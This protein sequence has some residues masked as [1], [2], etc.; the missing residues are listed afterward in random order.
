[1]KESILQSWVETRVNANT[2]G[3]S[4][5]DAEEVLASA[6]AVNSASF[7]PAFP[8]DYL[9]RRRCLESA[10][11]VLPLLANLDL[12]LANRN[13]SADA[14]QR[15][16]PDLIAFNPESQISII[17]ELKTD[18]KT[19]REAV[20]EL[21]AYSHEVRNHLPY[22]SNLDQ[23][24][25]LVAT[26]FG[27]LLDHAVAS[28]VL[29]E[30]RHV[31]CLRAEEIDG[32]TFR[33]RPHFPR[34]WTAIGQLGLPANALQTVS[35]CLY[36][37]DGSSLPDDDLSDWLLAAV[38]TTVRSAERSRSHGFAML[39]FAGPPGDVWIITVGV[40]NPYAFLNHA[41]SQG[42]LRAETD[43]LTRWY[44]DHLDDVHDDPPSLLQLCV[45][46]QELL[47]SH[48]NVTIESFLDW[49][50][51]WQQIR[52]R[53]LV[54][55]VD[56]WGILGDFAREM[57]SHPAL[58]KLRSGEQGL[59]PGW[60][61]PQSAIP[62]LNEIT[63]R[64]PF[65]RGQFGLGGMFRFGELLGAL[66]TVCN[67]IQSVRTTTPDA[68][69]L[70]AE[71]PSDLKNLPALLQWLKLEAMP[72]FRSVTERY[73]TCDLPTPPALVLGTAD[74]VEQMQSSLK[75]YVEWFSEQFLAE[76]LVHRQ[77]FDAGLA[78]HAIMDDYLSC[79]LDDHARSTALSSLRE[80]SRSIL[81]HIAQ[82]LPSADTETQERISLEISDAFGIRIGDIGTALEVTE[83]LES[84][85]YRDALPQ[86]LATADRVVPT[87]FH[88]L[89]EFI[90]EGVDWRWVREQ[91]DA[92]RSR[93][94]HNPGVM[95]A[96]DGTVGIGVLTD[97]V[98]VLRRY[99]P[100]TEVLV[101]RDVSGIHRIDIVAWA[102]LLSGSFFT[103]PTL[104]VQHSLAA[105]EALPPSSVGPRS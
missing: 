26:D 16:F 48:F 51:A 91:V 80:Y 100:A 13:V 99:D 53:G 76:N 88:R 84:L 57:S 96:A 64:N 66:L 101:A 86:L 21:M 20:T 71:G 31:L 42:F 74:H 103:G 98:Q 29:W 7:V 24:L 4:V 93:G 67:T 94:V 37:K 61:H 68:L 81:L 34:A 27:T 95:I 69:N 78:W 38:E 75:D 22:A 97:R 63:G 45:T 47:K 87:V 65:L 18:E 40:L 83:P 92:A 10:A 2:L 50:S 72:M 70:D 11:Y 82:T 19:E 46:A 102:E 56:F 105:D 5:M 3:E 35:L 73:L 59:P 1:M 17:F 15:L 89:E 77:A 39:W 58:Q 9:L 79:G 14:S 30:G 33:L 54:A 49:A 44:V 12:V 62:L 36:P 28:L 43:A 8:V 25:V 6:A 90:G 85:V 41:L 52:N 55:E 60:K 23:C 104:A 32:T